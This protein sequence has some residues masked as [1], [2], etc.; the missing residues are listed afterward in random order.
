MKPQP[1]QLSFSCRV[2]NNTP[3]RYSPF[4]VSTLGGG[5]IGK[6]KPPP[7]YHYFPRPFQRRVGDLD[8]PGRAAQI[9]T[10][11]NEW[12]NPRE[13]PRARG[14]T[15]RAPPGPASAGGSDWRRGR[16]PGMGPGRDALGR[17]LG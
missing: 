15:R 16:G 11:K 5:G 10:F 3:T 8:L 4:S 14:L 9:C 1:Q 2:P 13:R 12:G 6:R 17:R 7:T